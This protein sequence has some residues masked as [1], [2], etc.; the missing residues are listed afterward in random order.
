MRRL[1][2]IGANDHHNFYWFGW[3][4]NYDVICAEVK[5]IIA[6]QAMLA[7]EAGL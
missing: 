4:R 5:I 7:P 6:A 2:S 1:L 3:S